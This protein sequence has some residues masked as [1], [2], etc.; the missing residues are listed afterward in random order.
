MSVVTAPDRNKE[1]TENPMGAPDIAGQQKVEHQAASH[2][3]SL[4]QQ[5]IETKNKQQQQQQA[6]ENSNEQNQTKT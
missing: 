5:H 3:S 4:S 6:G 1:S 2:S